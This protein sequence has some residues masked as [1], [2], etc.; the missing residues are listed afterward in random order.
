SVG[1]LADRKPSANSACQLLL[2]TAHNFHYH[3]ARFVV[4]VVVVVVVVAAMQLLLVEAAETCL[5][6]NKLY[7]VAVAAAAD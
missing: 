5:W 2:S 6:L 3:S 4:V 1:Q 7:S